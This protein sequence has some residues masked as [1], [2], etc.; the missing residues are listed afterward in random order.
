VMNR[1]WKK[2]SMFLNAVI[3]KVSFHFAQTIDI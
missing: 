2:Q 3:N 1:T